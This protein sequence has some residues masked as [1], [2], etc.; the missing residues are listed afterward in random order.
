[1][2]PILSKNAPQPVGP[3]SQAIKVDGLLFISGQLGMDTDGQ[4]KDTI[5]NQTHQALKN[6]KAILKEEELGLEHVVKVTVFLSDMD[7]FERMNTV[8]K[9][10][11]ETP[12]R[13]CVGVDL[14][15][16]CKIEI[17]AIAAYD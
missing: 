9:K 7:D 4:I 8:Y 14:F 2:K 10:Y 3:Y 17:E 16:N 1:M 15:K 5:E 11:L 12:A 6:I 13:A